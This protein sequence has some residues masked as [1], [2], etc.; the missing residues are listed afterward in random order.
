MVFRNDPDAPSLK[1][2]FI[3]LDCMHVGVL[4]HSSM[5]WQPH[6]TLPLGGS[7]RHIFVGRLSFMLSDHVSVFAGRC[8]G[9]G[10]H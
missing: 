8:W 2:E 4:L 7:Q 1:L 5:V 6:Q 3:G 10:C 9:L